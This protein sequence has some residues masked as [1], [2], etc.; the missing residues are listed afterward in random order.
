[1]QRTWFMPLFRLGWITAMPYSQVFHVRALKVFR[2]FRMLQLYLLTRTR[3]FDHIPPIL[4]SLLWLPVHLR[5]DFMVLLMTNKT[6]HGLAPSY[7][8]DLI[9]PVIPTWSSSWSE[10]YITEIAFLFIVQFLRHLSSLS[11]EMFSKKSRCVLTKCLTWRYQR[12]TSWQTII[13]L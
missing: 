4:A 6:E 1:M 12:I 13:F 11:G 10:L 5:S 8:S 3:K 2:W 9:T 7:M